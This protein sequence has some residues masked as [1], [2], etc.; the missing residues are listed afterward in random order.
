LLVLLARSARQQV[1]PLA[2]MVHAQVNIAHH[3]IDV[4]L[5]TIM[6]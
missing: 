5:L 1:L 3:G 4:A 6:P 2:Q